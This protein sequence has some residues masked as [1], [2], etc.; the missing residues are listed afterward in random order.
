MSSS[1]MFKRALGCVAFAFLLID[2]ATAQSVPADYCG[3]EIAVDAP[4]ADK[5]NFRLRIDGPVGAWAMP[6]TAVYFDETALLAA[7]TVGG[8]PDYAALLQLMLD[9]PALVPPDWAT[10]L[11]VNGYEIDLTAVLHGLWMH[12]ASSTGLDD[13]ASALACWSLG[14]CSSPTP[15]TEFVT[16]V[17]SELCDGNWTAVN[18]AVTAQWLVP[19]LLGELEVKRYLQHIPLPSNVLAENLSVPGSILW[20]VDYPTWNG[21]SGVS[22]ANGTWGEI[23]PALGGL[24]QMLRAVPDDFSAG[25]PE[26]GA[27][28]VLNEWFSAERWVQHYVDAT[29]GDGEFAEL[30]PRITTAAP[31]PPAAGEKFPI[32]LHLQAVSIIDPSLHLHSNRAIVDPFQAI[33]LPSVATPPTSDPP[34]LGPS[35]WLVHGPRLR[36]LVVLVGGS[37]GIFVGPVATAGGFLDIPLRGLSAGG[38]TASFRADTRSWT[39]PLSPDRAGYARCALPSGI[40]AGATVWLDAVSSR[41]GTVSC[42]GQPWATIVVQ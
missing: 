6:A 23:T 2:G 11:T 22:Q 8:V 12:S 30:L 7:Y 32:A 17:L 18:P 20:S 36:P 27:T 40:P 25:E 39:L 31:N 33:A 5:T 24:W 38:L 16:P 19:G 26:Q 1:P 29:L 14:Y 9:Y 21:S 3:T 35:Q 34:R 13:I 4:Y 10:L 42:V 37:G 15:H 41:L 28:G